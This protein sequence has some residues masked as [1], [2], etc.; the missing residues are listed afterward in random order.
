M[1]TSNLGAQRLGAGLGVPARDW[2]QTVVMRAPNPNTRPVVIDKGPVPSALPRR[3]STKTEKCEANKAL[4]N[5]KNSIV[6]VNIL[7]AKILAFYASQ[8]QINNAE[9]GGNRKVALILS[10][11]GRNTVVSCLKNCAPH[12]H[13]E[14]SRGLYKMRTRSQESMMRNRVFFLFHCFKD[15]H[16]LAS[17]TQ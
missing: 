3:I 14:E 12:P 1:T 15:S 13:H 17:V 5:G 8:S 11:Q 10:Q 9:F 7:L 16:R 2:G 6:H 4:I